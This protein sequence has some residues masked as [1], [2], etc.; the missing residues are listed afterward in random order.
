MLTAEKLKGFAERVSETMKNVYPFKKMQLRLNKYIVAITFY[1]ESLDLSAN[2][3]VGPSGAI[4]GELYTMLTFAV[5][6]F[7]SIIA[8]QTRF[9]STTEHYSL[10]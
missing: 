3:K 4:V 9:R 2:S 10:R 7:L 6:L 5:S 1:A 8:T